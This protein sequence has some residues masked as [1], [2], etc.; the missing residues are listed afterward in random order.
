MHSSSD[1]AILM[2]KPLAMSDTCTEHV[3]LVDET[4][5]VTGTCE[6]I[7]AHEAG[8]LHRAFSIF[9]VDN[10]GRLLVQQRQTHKYHSGGLWANSCCGHPRPGEK[11]AEAAERRLIEELGIC[12]P[13]WLKFRARYREKTGDGLVENE[14]VEVYFGKLRAT[15]APDPREISALCVLSL[16][17]LQK[18]VTANPDCWTV[19]MRHYLT[20]HLPNLRSALEHCR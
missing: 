10:Q 20:F 3:V 1:A 2:V 8:L 7:K 13:L 5:T 17:D 9:L 15:P 18:C 14:I 16:E 4:D 11:T 19:W 12:T 6:K